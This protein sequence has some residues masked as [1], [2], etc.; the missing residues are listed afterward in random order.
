M[1]NLISDDDRS[2]KWA[3]FD[4]DGRQVLTCGQDGNG[5]V[6][7]ARTG[8]PITPRLRH[9]WEIE[10]GSFS[11]NGKFVITASRDRT[12]KIWKLPSGEQ[13]APALVHFAGVHNA[14][15]TPDGRQVVTGARDGTARVWNVVDGSPATPPLSIGTGLVRA[16][17]S[18]CGRF[19]ATAG[20]SKV[21]LW[22]RQ[23]GQMLGLP[24]QH[25]DWTNEV[26]F[27]PDS[28]TMCTASEDGS[29]RVWSIPPVD[30]Q[31]VESIQRQ[32][33]LISG[34]RADPISGLVPLTSEELM[35]LIKND[36]K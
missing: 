10:G 30:E 34:H 23:T 15:F 32:A 16:R 17:I 19:V 20:S 29:A 22:D 27:S 11:P 35:S 36:A 12:A 7:D 31:F 6:W 9:A 5:R 14:S 24:F 8:Q 28:K 2:V 26:R 21:M 25:G 18:P 33:R 13:A 3:T 4:S 1:K